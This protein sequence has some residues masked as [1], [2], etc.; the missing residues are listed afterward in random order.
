MLVA[1]G[2]EEHLG[3]KHQAGTPQASMPV[4]GFAVLLRNAYQYKPPRNFGC[5]FDNPWHTD[6]L[7]DRRTIVIDY[8]LG[9][10][11]SSSQNRSCRG[12]QAALPLIAPIPK[13]TITVPKGM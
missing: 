5:R 4:Y 8:R 7:P 9:P 11:D 10:D 1:H 13:G 2:P 6:R 3:H 12:D